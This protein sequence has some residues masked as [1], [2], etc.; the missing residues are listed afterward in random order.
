MDIQN[1]ETLDHRTFANMA[2][3][4]GL[5]NVTVAAEGAEWSILAQVRKTFFAIASSRGGLRTFS[6][7]DTAI[8]YLQGIGVCQ[9]E[10]DARNYDPQSKSRAR[11]PDR[12]EALRNAHKAAAHDQWF[13]EQVVASLEEANSPTAVWHS[14]EE[15]EA[16]E[17][18]LFARLDKELATGAH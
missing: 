15:L 11:R 3:A 17:K 4:G 8:K 18:A 5:T 9:F 12:A 7:S 10:V 14:S 1:V 2:K 16:S 6:H 13:K